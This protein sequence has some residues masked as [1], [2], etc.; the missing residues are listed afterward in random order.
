M[1][2]ESGS[3]IIVDDKLSFIQSVIKSGD[4]DVAVKESSAVFEMAFRKIFQQAIVTLDYKDRSEILE[5][6]KKIG[7]GTK[8]VQNFTFGELV[9]LFRESKLMDKWSRHTSKD[10]GLIKSL[11]YSAIVTL[12]NKLVHNGGT[13][14]R[15]EANLVYEYLRNLLAELGLA[16]LDNSINQSFTKKEAVPVTEEPPTPSE[17]HVKP[18]LENRL[19]KVKKTRGKSYYSSSEGEEKERLKIQSEIM[20]AVDVK[21]FDYILKQFGDQTDLIAL[22]VG[23][24][25]GDV[26]ID[27]FSQYD[28]FRKVIG[29][30]INPVKVQEANENSQG[31]DKFSFYEMDIESAEF[32]DRLTEALV[33]H[34]EKKFDVIFSALTLHHLANPYKAIYRLR[35]HLKKDGYIVLR[36]SDDGSKMAYPDEENL[37][38]SIISMSSDIQG[39]SDRENGRKLYHQ[40]K[41]SGFKDVKLFYN[42]VDTAS[43][44]TDERLALFIQSFSYRKD[45]FEKKLKLQP[46]DQK[47]ME[48]LD[49]ITEALEELE[50]MFMDETFYYIETHTV[51]V[52]KK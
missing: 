38:Q 26:T 18:S 39:Q 2:E 6:E 12:R 32:D 44:T 43:M 37:V 24:A 1:N 47:L 30:D 52:G 25:A 22:D 4:Y 23:S 33:E 45:A 10:L 35:K 19:P 40:V 48:K 16:D 29:I 31:K 28:Q 41:K 20:R 7:K 5:I 51:A 34:G 49:W 14:S 21:A 15:S 36:G 42:L 9:G 27:R 46:S 13:C 50:L 17:D 11:D 3:A 8:G